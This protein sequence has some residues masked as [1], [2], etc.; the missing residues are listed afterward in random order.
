VRLVD[1]VVRQGH[2]SEQALA[3]AIVTGDRP[4]HLDR[5]DICATRALDLGRWLDQVREA[6]VMS[7]DR[8]FPAERLAAQ[9]AQILRRLEQLDEPARVIAFPKQYRLAT[10]PAGAHRVASAWVGVAAAA[11]LFIGAIGGHFSATTSKTGQQPVTAAQHAAQI[12]APAAPVAPAD[13]S[14]AMG[15]IGPLGNGNDEQP[16]A[17]DASLLDHELDGFTPTAMETLDGVT[18][19]LLARS[20]R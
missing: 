8:A 11:G 14:M 3:E 5:C 17:S 12:A 18:P 20:P 7:A 2:L 19:T 1:F 4:E 9:Q 15:A 6:A 10:A 13:A 16:I